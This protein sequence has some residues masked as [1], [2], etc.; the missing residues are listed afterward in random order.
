MESWEKD[1]KVWGVDGKPTKGTRKGS[2]KWRSESPVLQ[3]PN[4]ENK[5]KSKYM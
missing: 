2:Q 1:T 3:K 5:T 4:E